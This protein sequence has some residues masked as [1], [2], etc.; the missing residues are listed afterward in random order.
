M[1]PY[2]LLEAQSHILERMADGANLTETLDSICLL[3]EQL[4]PPVLCS[5]MGM[6]PDG[7]HLTTLAGPS[8]PLE[9]RRAVLHVAVG[10]RKGSCGTAA[11][12]KE[13]V[14][15]T[16]I[17]CDPL[18]DEFRAAALPFGLRACW[19]LPV[20]HPDGS[21][22]GTVALYY[23]EP[24]SPESSDFALVSP[25]IK[26]M[27]LAIIAA[28]KEQELQAATVRWQLGSEVIGVG[29]Y[30]A[31]P[32]K[33][34]NKWSPQLRRMLGVPDDAIPSFEG[35]LD[36]V[37]PEDR[38]VVRSNMPNYPDPPYHSPWRHTL[39][40]R[41]ADTGEERTLQNIG[42][43]VTD[44]NGGGTHIVGTLVDVT[45][46]YQREQELSEAKIAAEAANVAKSKFLASMSHELRTPLNAIIG[47][48]DIIKSRVFGP[49]TPQRYEGYIEDIHKSGTHLLSLINDVLDMAKIEAQ[50]FELHRGTVLLSELADGALLLVRPQA[51]A[52]G[53]ELSLDIPQGLTLH[54]DGRAMRQVLTNFL[55]NAV[56]FTQEHGTIR[57]FG[58]RLKGGGLALGVEDSGVGMTEEGIALALEPFGQV[59]MDVANERAGT[60]LGLP[61]AKALIEYHGATFHITSAPGSG[62]KV[63]GEFPLKDVGEVARRMR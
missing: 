53:V 4:A 57:L 44:P 23:R 1:T 31:D 47:F 54:V 50:R 46:Q 8:L 30:D 59:A 34:R 56:K 26:L 55:A 52:K 5:V 36:L 45:E 15:V 7:A 16:D 19:S 39:R 37:V 60:G 24:R 49:L 25:C 17:A 21:V 48:S 9:Y 20:L 18:W 2:A 42:C 10:P 43:V 27:R 12:R 3:V 63:W 40:I 61:I 32:D 6:K 14:I 22:L 33:N 35:F 51:L 13:A 28:R 38:E 58:H 29:H 41:R 62:T 11:F